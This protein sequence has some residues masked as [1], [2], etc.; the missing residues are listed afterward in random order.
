[1]DGSAAYFYSSG[2]RQRLAATRCR[3]DVDMYSE[4]DTPDRRFW[5]SYDRFKFE[6]EARALRRAAV[7]AMLRIAWRRIATAFV[8]AAVRP[9]KPQRARPAT[10]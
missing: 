10:M 6:Q 5:T 1:L 8:G 7:A 4:D 2:R 9:G 3:K